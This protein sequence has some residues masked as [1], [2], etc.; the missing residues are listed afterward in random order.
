MCVASFQCFNEL[1]GNNPRLILAQMTFWLLV[2]SHES[3][4]V[5]A[6][7]VRQDHNKFLLAGDQ[8]LEG[9]NVVLVV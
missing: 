2:R 1:L 3:V 5:A 8:L 4:K 6:R 7:E 9:H